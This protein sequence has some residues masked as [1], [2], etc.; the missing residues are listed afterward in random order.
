[1]NKFSFIDTNLQ[2]VNFYGYI[3]TYKREGILGVLSER[4]LLL[5]IEKK[6]QHKG[7]ISLNKFMFCVDFIQDKQ[8]S[9]V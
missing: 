4:V 9:T 1:M 5:L 6:K 8:P 3:Y 7:Q 2:G